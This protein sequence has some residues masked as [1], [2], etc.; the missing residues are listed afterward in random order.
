MVLQKGL[1]KEA[2]F[3][4]KRNLFLSALVTTLLFTFCAGT[5]AILG[6]EINKRTIELNTLILKILLILKLLK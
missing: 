1:K 5:Q 4:R 3:K 6:I 2:L